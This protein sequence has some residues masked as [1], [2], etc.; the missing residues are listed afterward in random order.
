MSGRAWAAGVVVVGCLAAWWWFSG[1]EDL[2]GQT[3]AM[4]RSL[5]EGGAAGR[6]GRRAVDQIMRNIDRMRPDDIRAV[7]RSLETDWQQAREK[8]VEAYFD[9]RPEERPSILDRSIDRTLVYKELR[10]AVNPRSRGLD[11]RRS[12]K[13]PPAAA[14][15]ATL[16]PDAA[17]RRQLLERYD[18]ALRQRARER[19]IDLPTWQPSPR[20]PPA[21]APRNRM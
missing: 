11:G 17:A 9:A 10:F 15:A 18:D 12:R 4:E 7:Q 3:L 8:D 19:R 21:V 5:L 13:P 14:N 16:D 6:A 2:V 1:R 20:D